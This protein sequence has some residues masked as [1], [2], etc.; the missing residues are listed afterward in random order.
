ME[1]HPQMLAT[2][3]ILLNRAPKDRVSAADTS[4]DMRETYAIGRL[5]AHLLQVFSP[6]ALI[7]RRSPSK[8]VH[9]V[10]FLMRSTAFSYCHVLLFGEKTSV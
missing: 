8:S 7:S 2:Q 4:L 9:R 6:K 3:T 5:R 10:S 1:I